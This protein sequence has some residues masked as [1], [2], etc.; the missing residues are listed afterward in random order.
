MT[1]KTS[2][3]PFWIPFAAGWAL[4]VFMASTNS[5]LA[6]AASPNGILDHQS[7]GTAARVD[8]IQHAWAAAGSL[9]FAQLSMGLDLVFIGL[10]TIGALVACALIWR[11]ASGALKLFAGLTALAWLAFGATDYTETI[12]QV[13]QAHSAGADNLAGL[14]ASVGLVKSVSFVAGNVA[15]IAALLWHRATVRK[16]APEATPVV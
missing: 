6:T 3:R 4:F 11:R 7:A 9:G 8:E 13:V 12:A 10:V 5:R 1:T 16:A 15:L 2:W 14:A